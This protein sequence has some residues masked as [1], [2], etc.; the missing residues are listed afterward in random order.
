[1]YQ[2]ESQ[3]RQDCNRIKESGGIM[4]GIEKRLKTY[5]TSIGAELDGPRSAAKREPLRSGSMGQR[6]YGR[7]PSGSDL[8][9]RYRMRLQENS[10][11]EAKGVKSGEVYDHGREMK[12]IIYGRVRQMDDKIQ[13][14]RQENL[15]FNKDLVSQT[16]FRETG[17]GLDGDRST[18]RGMSASRYSKGAVDED[19]PSRSTAGLSRPTSGI[20]DYYQGKP[21]AKV[22]GS[23]VKSVMSYAGGKS[24]MSLNESQRMMQLVESQKKIIFELQGQMKHQRSKTNNLENNIVRYDGMLEKMKAKLSHEASSH[25]RELSALSTER[26]PRRNEVEEHLMDGTKIEDA[27]DRQAQTVDG[28]QQVDIQEMMEAGEKSKRAKSVK[29]VTAAKRFKK[30]ANKLAMAGLFKQEKKPDKKQTIGK[31]KETKAKE[32]VER[33]QKK[34]LGGKAKLGLGSG[35]KKVKIAKPDVE[36]ELLNVIADLVVKKMSAKKQQPF[37]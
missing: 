20:A 11:E 31:E 25:R 2:S 33:L 30:A 8:E 6:G 18:M 7:V 5:L 17:G 22:I 3:F 29:S 32:I 9:A 12:E 26:K 4:E 10:R 24:N 14:Y 15:R 13:R 28:P 27:E 37:K 34:V 35:W 19:E 23:S 36:K 16:G 1:M 21:Q